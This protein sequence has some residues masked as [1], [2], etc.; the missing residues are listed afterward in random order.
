M[1]KVIGVLAITLVFA[2]LVAGCSKQELEQVKA[3]LEK[4]KAEL[5][6][7][8]VELAKTRIKLAATEAK[9]RMS[10]TGV[11]F[12]DR[13]KFELEPAKQRSLQIDITAPATLD[14]KVVEIFGQ[15][16][17]FKVLKEGQEVYSSGVK[18][19]NASC[20]IDV[21]LGVYSV[22][23]TNANLMETKKGE[24]TIVARYK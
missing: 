14:I 16:I 6:Q 23:V 3:E 17:E 1:K 15:N 19:G 20:S 4:T 22:V 12:C 24:V 21:G 7:T 13:D 9:V 2:F 5:V 8:Q 18:K 10:I 11:T